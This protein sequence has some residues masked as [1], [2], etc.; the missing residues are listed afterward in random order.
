MKETEDALK[1]QVTEVCWG[2]NLQ[3]WTEALNLAKVDASSKL[4]KIENIFYPPALRKATQPTSKETI[5]PKALL[6]AQPINTI[7][8]TSEPTK[9][10]EAKHSNPPP[11]ATEAESSNPP[12]ATTNNPPPST[13]P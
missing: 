13:N 7:A 12:L 6:V 4:R 8:A 11:A 10:T 9:E 1:A 5:A 2:Y 3:V